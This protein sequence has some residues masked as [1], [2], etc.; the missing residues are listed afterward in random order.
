MRRVGIV[1]AGLIGRWHA[2]RW[3][4][5]PV[6]LAGF[7]D[8]VPEAAQAAS[9]EV[10]GRAYE[11]MDALLAD[12]DVVDV[13]TITTAHKDAVLAAAAAGK[14]IV[15]EKP[16]ARHLAECEEMVAACEAAGVRLFV[17]Q[18]VRFFPQ[19][20]RAKAVI[21]EGLL[22][23]VGVIRTIRAGRA[24]SRPW[25][26]DVELSGGVIMDVSIHDIDFARWCCG[27]VERVFARGLTFTDEASGDHALITLRFTSGAIGHIEG[28]WSHPAGA[29]RT[30]LEIAGTEGLIEWDSQE[31]TS[32]RLAIN[33][34][35]GNATRSKESPLAPQDDPYYRELAHFL[36]CL[37]SGEPF[38]VSPHDGLMAVKVSLAAI[39]SMRRGEPVDIATFKEEKA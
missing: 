23:E 7:Y 31:D 26:L 8:I 20:A 36:E 25:F 30:R 19:F 6:E 13:C 11:S 35:N 9:E 33:H 1:G 12:V 24:P 22:G 28:S 18:V 29:F 16:L 34:P 2:E 32:V 14:A 5:L 39:E 27:E 4:Q 3:Q 37:D 15:C 38:L 10:G 21:D 17:A